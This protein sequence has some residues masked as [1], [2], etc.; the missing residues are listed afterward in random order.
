V[1]FP[2]FFGLTVAAVIAALMSTLDTL[3]TAVAAVAVND[4]G[5][6][7]KPGLSDTIYLSLAKKITL[8]VTLLGVALISI[9]DQFESIY[10]AL[11]HFTS[12]VIPPLMV[13]ILLGVMTTWFS[14]RAAKVTLVFGA[15]AMGLSIVFP[16]LITPFAHGIDAAGGYSY[17]RS[18]YGFVVSLIIAGVASVL[19]TRA[20]PE[21]SEGLCLW[22]IE[23]AKKSLKGAE[24]LGAFHSQKHL[25]QWRHGS[26]TE[27]RVTL[28]F[29][30]MRKLDIEAG[31]HVFVSDPRWWLGGYRSVRLI[32][33]KGHVTDT[34]LLSEKSAK[35][36]G[37]LEGTLS[38]Q[39]VL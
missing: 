14:A 33:N 12:M 24:R 36:G 39:R 17:I 34:L 31:D 6:Q 28:P 32:A 10:K 20:N 26:V 38:I 16:Q 35:Q 2:G 23:E 37:L 4:I 30:V 29:E 13:V 18:F 19:F 1:S 15:T 9:F 5:R 22:S 11:S 27:G 21:D 7:L 25:A 3:I 8:G